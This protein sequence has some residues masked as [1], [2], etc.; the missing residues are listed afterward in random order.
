MECMRLD[1]S[2]KPPS[3]HKA[4]GLCGARF[5]PASCDVCGLCFLHMCMCLSLTADSTDAS[6]YGARRFA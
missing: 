4:S 3:S 2:S 6:I 5:L 1:R